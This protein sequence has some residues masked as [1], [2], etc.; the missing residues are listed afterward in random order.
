MDSGK[1][2]KIAYAADFGDNNF[3]NFARTKLEI[4]ILTILQEQIWLIPI[5][6]A[7]FFPI[8]TME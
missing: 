7:I 5:H 4:I 6:S 2:F 1:I 8:L 3:D